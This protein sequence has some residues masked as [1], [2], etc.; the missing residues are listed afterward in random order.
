M[1]HHHHHIS[2]TQTIGMAIGSITGILKAGMMSSVFVINAITTSIE[3]DTA[4]LAAIGATCGFLVT[5]LWSYIWTLVINK[6]KARKEKNEK[7]S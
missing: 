5:K 2:T 7:V 3:I 1:V 6:I 4:I